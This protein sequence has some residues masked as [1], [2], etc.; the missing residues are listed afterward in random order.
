MFC[1][2]EGVSA[3]GHRAKAGRRGTTRL[4]SSGVILDLVGQNIS[5][6][7]DEFVGVC[8]EKM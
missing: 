4:A 2:W 5:H 8:V 7:G 6:L 1:S 3:L